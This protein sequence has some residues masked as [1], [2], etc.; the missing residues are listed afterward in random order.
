MEYRNLGPTG[1]KVSVISYGNW[2]NS[3]SPEAKQLT[4]DCV[5]TAWDM[6]IN[7]FD[8][9][10]VYG[11]GEAERQIGAA[12]KQLNVPRHQFVLSTKVFWG[13]KD[14]IPN[15]RGLSRK[16]IIEGMR[17]CLKN[18]DY[19]YVDVVFCHRPD[20]STPL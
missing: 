16:H 12:L 8:T 13:V 2:L 9:A 1:I 20:Y 6:G 14:Q 17:K 19:D 15:M 10:E 3:N 4:A 7:F 5:K 11:F 18:L